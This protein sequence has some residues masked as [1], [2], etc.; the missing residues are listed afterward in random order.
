MRHGRRRLN[1]ALA[2]SLGIQNSTYDF[3]PTGATGAMNR[4]VD[5]NAGK[6]LQGRTDTRTGAQEFRGAQPTQEVMTRVR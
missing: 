3:K 1:K 5:T 2:E 6:R 4:L